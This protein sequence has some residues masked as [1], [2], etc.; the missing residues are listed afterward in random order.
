[1]KFSE[2]E[3]LAWRYWDEIPETYK[4]GVDGLVIERDAL[5]HPTLPEIY[6][7]GE[8]V[9]EAYPSGFGGPDTIRSY[10]LLYYGSF[11]RLSRQ[12]PDFDWEDELWETLT[13]E[14]QH[15][16]ES[17]AEE[18]ALIAMD[19]ANDE[20]FKRLDGEP[21]DPFFYRS[22]EEVAEGVWRVERDVFF[23]QRYPASREPGAEVEIVWHGEP[24]RLVRPAELG[25]ICFITSRRGSTRARAARS[26][27]SSSGNAG[28]AHCCA[29]SSAAPPRPSSRLRPARRRSKRRGA[30]RTRKRGTR[31]VDARL[32]V[33][34]QP[35]HPRPRLPAEP[36]I[37]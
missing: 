10:V 37:D 36:S 13:H 32:A 11:W 5:P 33:I 19:Y 6:T 23:E 26:T 24:Y 4:E 12:S 25:D 1:M 31:N 16:L 3:E 18:D 35:V 29:R 20:N 17:L 14:L 28:S 15:H 8:C 21:F 27:W 2:F 34:G 9:T 30:R 22:G 7:L